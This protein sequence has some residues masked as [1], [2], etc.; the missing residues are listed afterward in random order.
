MKYSDLIRKQVNETDEA[1]DENLSMNSHS[2]P[3]Y[4][5]QKQLKNRNMAKLKAWNREIEK[6]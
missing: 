5:T 3:T 4:H 2:A 6:K 1:L